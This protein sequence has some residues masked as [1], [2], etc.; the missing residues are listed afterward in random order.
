MILLLLFSIPALLASS[1]VVTTTNCSF[2]G[3]VGSWTCI[4]GALLNL[5]ATT[6]VAWIF[7]LAQANPQR[8]IISESRD[9]NATI[10]SSVTMYNV[11]AFVVVPSVTIH[12]I[13][14][15]DSTFA[16]AFANHAKPIYVDSAYVNDG[17]WHPLPG[18]WEA[19]F[20]VTWIGNSMLYTS[21]RV[22][23]NDDDQPKRLWSVFA[24][25]SYDIASSAV[26]VRCCCDDGREEMMHLETFQVIASSEYVKHE[27]LGTFQLCYFP[28]FAQASGLHSNT[29]ELSVDDITSKW[30]VT[31][32]GDDNDSQEVVL[33]YC[34]S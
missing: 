25:A 12:S 22:R 33:V 8:F 2:K 24:S 13:V 14:N 23:D 18:R 5:P 31:V 21:L 19:C 26:H 4:D 9:A 16:K 10:V 3:H 15:R 30:Y 6:S 34:V 11:N 7:N 17:Y 29:I 27:L 20:P 32:T 28:S 1:S